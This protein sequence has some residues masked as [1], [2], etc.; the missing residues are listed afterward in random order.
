M[1][2]YSS[3]RATDFALDEFFQRWV[4]RADPEATD[5]WERWLVEHPNRRAEV[6]E[7]RRMVLTLGPAET[8]SDA[9][10][11]AR[12][13]RA[14][15][16]R[17]ASSHPAPPRDVQLPWK[18]LAACLLILLLAGGGGFWGYQQ[19]SYV[20]YTTPYGKS[21]QFT[22]P[23]GSTVTLKANSRLRYARRWASDQ[24]R[25]VWLEGDAFFH[26]TKHNIPREGEDDS[27]VS[28]RA[29]FTVH[30]TDL[31]DVAVLGTE[32]NV[33]TRSAE[34][35]V[36][37]KSGSVRLEVKHHQPQTVLMEP[38]DL[39]AVEHR[40][41]T[42]T[43]QRIDAPS[44]TAWQDNMLIFNE[45]TLA[46][47]ARKLQHTYGVTVVFQ[48]SDLAQR[49]FKGFVPTDNLDMLLEAF[50]ELYDLRIERNGNQLT[51]SERAR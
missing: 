38:G 40:R 46:T 41:G 23:D 25:E 11:N 10:R 7:A 21:H 15:L 9:Q 48:R 20:R 12:L 16:A 49:K 24:D 32:F 28:Q 26:V 5:F 4:L 47:V 35:E 50:T 34:T 17:I 39:V 30:A 6:E 2:P 44:L 31:V 42:L 14:V 33:S 13:K 3:Y 1:D 22:L 18:W 27:S 43:Q 36:A 19:W 29:R 37:L 51:F 8:A 45:A